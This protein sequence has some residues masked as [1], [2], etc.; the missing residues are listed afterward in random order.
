MGKEEVSAETPLA[1]A[2]ALQRVAN[3]F[4]NK[5]DLAHA[6][7]SYQA[8]MA[9]DASYPAARLG[10]GLV[11]FDQ[12]HFSR[13]RACFEEAHRLQP[14]AIDPL[15]FVA[16]C[17]E[18]LH[19]PQQA[20]QGYQLALAINPSFV[21]ALRALAPLAV[22]LGRIEIAEHRLKAAIDISPD[23]I[24]L[25]LL[26]AI[27]LYAAGRHRESIP[28]FDAVLKVDPSRLEALINKAEA[29]VSLERA[30]DAQ[31]LV[32]RLNKLAPQ[33]PEVMLLTARS[34]FN[35]GHVDEAAIKAQQ[36]LALDARSAMAEF[37]LGLVNWSKSD[38]L[39][40]KHHWQRARAFDP[41]LSA[42]G[43]WIATLLFFENDFKAAWPAFEA[44]FDSSFGSMNADSLLLRR[45][46]GGRRWLGEPDAD[47]TL[48]LW[49]EQGFGDTLMLLPEVAKV[50]QRFR[51]TVYFFCPPALRPLVEQLIA[52][53]FL[54]SSRNEIPDGALHC[55]LY[56]V[57]AVLQS[58]TETVFQP[59]PRPAYL[60]APPPAIAKFHDRLE[61]LDGF[62]IGVIWDGFGGYKAN[63]LRSVPLG[64]FS[65]IA[66]IP[67]VT[68][69]SLQKNPPAADLAACT[70][71]LE[72]WTDDISDFGDTAAIMQGLDLVISIDSAPAHL[73]GAL[74]VPVWLLNR[75]GG[76]WRWGRARSD[77][78]WY[79]S[80]RVFYQSTRGD[81]PAVF[82]DMAAVL[83]HQLSQS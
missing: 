6:L 65:D 41:N 74:G 71:S 29:L 26:L 40:A 15:Y 46:A 78:D 31:S 12:Q 4:R 17:D 50:A 80:M 38:A 56:S 32:D 3:E 53:Q 48:Y 19:Q 67:G 63:L 55:P 44:R 76:E 2:Q 11:H 58:A 39:A 61:R 23:D 30:N 59:V 57:P 7:E 22:Q 47:G 45:L 25:R 68:L 33:R 79:Q 18:M 66:S 10:A 13:A 34:L 36:L 62:K 20:L 70:F 9:A 28:E 82:K 35:A 54:L 37:V 77:N 42:A 14:N 72:D 16:L 60:A 73:A 83:S 43:L 69:V 5:G 8:A 1:Q 49:A 27:T 21:P 51:G 81:W 75:Y 64:L 52:P 24:E